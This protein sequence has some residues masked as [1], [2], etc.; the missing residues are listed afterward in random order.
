MS[1]IWCSMFSGDPLDHRGPTP[2]PM[3]VGDVSDPSR[4]GSTTGLPSSTP[5]TLGVNDS[6]CALATGP[7]VLPL[8]EA[9][10]AELGPHDF[11]QL[12]R[13][14]DVPYVE[15]GHTCSVQADVHIYVNDGIPAR[16]SSAAEKDALQ[17]IVRQNARRH[18]DAVIAANR[19][20]HNV[21]I[22][23][24]YYGKGAPWE[25]RI[26][27]A[28]A[29]TYGR[30][31]PASLATYCDTTAKLGVD[32]SGFVNSFLVSTGHTDR[33]RDIDVYARNTART[34]YAQI[35]PFDL[36]IWQRSDGD[37]SRH[38]A[39]VDHVT[40][41][42]EMV[43]V[44]SSGSKGGLASSTYTVESVAGNIFQVDRGLDENGAAYP[45]PSS[46]KIVAYQ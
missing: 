42:N 27:L 23:H 5:G 40:E 28:Y 26:Y 34:S 7:L 45:H 41:S 38:I 15:D 3:G 39:I 21:A 32:C 36:L 20:A 6:T 43:V 11:M 33:E 29:L 19:S 25:Y 10:C 12:Y 22:A 24:A 9:G 37:A 8:T 16:R 2:G 1:L 14:L 13:E 4:A 30:A 46:V 18:A 17:S 31:T 35:Q 44:E